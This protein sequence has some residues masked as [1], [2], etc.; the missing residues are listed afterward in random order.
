M[1]MNLTCHTFEARNDLYQTAFDNAIG[2][3]FDDNENFV[4][5]KFNANNIT[6]HDIL[7]FMSSLNE[8]ISVLMQFYIER[9]VFGE[10]EEIDERK[11]VR[12]MKLDLLPV[13][14]THPSF[15]SESPAIKVKFK[16][17]KA[18]V[19]FHE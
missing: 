13:R 8:K 7:I 17:T 10:N 1:K 9:V 14:M 18:D 2:V 3:E 5:I 11:L 19:I 4:Y 12:E 16:Y 6:Y 15:P